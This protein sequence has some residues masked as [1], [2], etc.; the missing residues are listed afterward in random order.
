MAKHQ[1][2]LDHAE[3]GI[4]GN[5]VFRYTISQDSWDEVSPMPKALGAVGAVL[6]GNTI[7][8][9]GGLNQL[10][11]TSFHFTYDINR[12]I[13]TEQKPMPSPNDHMA[14]VTDGRRIF[15]T[16]GRETF[17]DS[18]TSHLY[19]YDSKSDSW[20]E[21]PSLPTPRGDAQGAMIGKYFIVAGG[22]NSQGK[23]FNV[24]EAL[25]IG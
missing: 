1:Q 24:V 15:I 17:A 22:E 10:G 13:W 14:M 19:I 25:D 9:M 7:H 5:K 11:P 12:D 23:V 20:Q 2:N 18:I 8:T 6:I 21:G 4:P 16:G 3:T